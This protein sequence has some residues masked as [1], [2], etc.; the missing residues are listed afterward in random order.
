M[1]EW[2]KDENSACIGNNK[3]MNFIF[4]ALSPNEFTRISQC[5]IVK[6]AWDIFKI[7]HEGTKTVKSSKLQMLISKFEE[8]KMQEN[9]NFDEFYVKLSIIRNSTINLGKKFSDAKMMKKIMRSLPERFIPK[10]NAIEEIKDLDSM[11]VEELVD[12]L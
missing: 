7:T 6:E 9:E 12:S 2:T 1:A 11:K 5:E 10:V 8:I 3:A 4:M